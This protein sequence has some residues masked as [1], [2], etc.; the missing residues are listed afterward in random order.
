MAPQYK[1][2]G[3][4]VMTETHFS[5]SRLHTPK[6][7]CSRTE[8]V[9]CLHNFLDSVSRSP[10]PRLLRGGAPSQTDKSLPSKPIKPIKGNIQS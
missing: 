1:A 7:P 5:H 2:D 3:K 6:G 8:G 10:Q 9:E 4:F